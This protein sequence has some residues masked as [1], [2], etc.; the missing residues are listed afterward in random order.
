MPKP[1]ADA[2]GIVESG[3]FLVVGGPPVQCN[4]QMHDVVAELRVN[5]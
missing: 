4:S 2:A 1:I 5:K 3:N